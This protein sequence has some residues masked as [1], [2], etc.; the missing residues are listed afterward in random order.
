[1]YLLLLCSLKHAAGDAWHKISSTIVGGARELGRKVQEGHLGQTLSEKLSGV[2]AKVCMLALRVPVVMSAF[3]RSTVVSAC[4][5][6]HNSLN[7]YWLYS[8]QLTDP[9]LAAKV[10]DKASSLLHSA[11]GLF[12]R[13]AAALDVRGSSS[14]S[15][16]LGRPS[17][18]GGISGGSAVDDDAF[19]ATSTSGRPP[20]PVT[21]QSSTSSAGGDDWGDSWEDSAS[22]SRPKPL[23]AKP[24]APAQDDDDFG[25]WTSF[26]V[27]SEKAVP[28][29]SSKP[30]SA[31]SSPSGSPR[32][33]GN[34]SPAPPPAVVAPQ[35]SPLVSAPARVKTG[36]TPVGLGTPPVKS[37]DFFASFGVAVTK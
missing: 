17:G 13:A 5:L 22:S 32:V 8:L 15:M 16:N 19:P 26:G 1:M 21:K 27:S 33:A 25:D 29:P 37:D 35:A 3:K 23:K 30:A 36:G 28:K 2:G 4:R 10:S 31:A 24:A 6:G 18:Y 34:S 9:A 14:A 20:V 11:T 12:S 7:S